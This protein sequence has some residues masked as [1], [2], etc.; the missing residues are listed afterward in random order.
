MQ[1]RQA[2]GSSNHHALQN[3]C[4]AGSCDWAARW[5]NSLLHCWKRRAGSGGSAH[6]HLWRSRSRHAGSVT[7]GGFQKELGMEPF[8]GR[9]LMVWS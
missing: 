7:V 9:V 8:S 2:L 5:V 4:S 6:P 3:T 1:Q